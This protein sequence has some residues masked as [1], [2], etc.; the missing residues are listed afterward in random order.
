MYL[1]IYGGSINSQQLTHNAFAHRDVHFDAVM[2][3]Y[4][5][6]N[7][8]RKANEAFLQEWINLME[9]VWNE[10]VYQ[11]YCNVNVPDYPKNYWKDALPGL[12][13]VKN[14]YDPD[15]KFQFSQMVPYDLPAG[16][17]TN[18]IDTQV[19]AALAKPIDYTGGIPPS[20]TKS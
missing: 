11:N 5:F 12:V 1:E 3:V 4:W 20:A 19:A 17:S 18:V 2:D 9:T 8:D 10:G 15:R 6:N 14:K 16:Y 7:V 13:A